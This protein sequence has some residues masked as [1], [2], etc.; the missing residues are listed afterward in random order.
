MESLKGDLSAFL[1]AYRTSR[2]VA[3]AEKESGYRLG[4]AYPPA[5]FYVYALI[6]PVTQEIFYIGKGIGGRVLKHEERTRR[7]VLQNAAKVKRIQQIFAAGHEAE[8]R[9]LFVSESE[10]VALSVEDNIIHELADFGLTNIIGGN[11]IQHPL[12]R[13]VAAEL[14]KELDEFRR[15]FVKG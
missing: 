12:V 6:D 14:R 8:R 7:G 4:T 2:N 3:Q 10:E 1:S 5:G 13:R 15:E 11:A 9:I